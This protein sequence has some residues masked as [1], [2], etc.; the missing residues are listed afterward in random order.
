VRLPK[1]LVT[2]RSSS[3]TTTKAAAAASISGISGAA[4]Q[5]KSHLCIPFL[6]TAQPQSLCRW[7]R[8]A[9]LAKGKKFRP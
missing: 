7:F 5:G 3:A 9:Q 1:F 4:L 2:G 8:F 6:G